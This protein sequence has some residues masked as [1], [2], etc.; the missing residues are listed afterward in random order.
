MQSIATKVI[1]LALI[2]MISKV[3]SYVYSTK[4]IDFI[5]QFKKIFFC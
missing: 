3:V 4:Q 5:I 1:E 2:T